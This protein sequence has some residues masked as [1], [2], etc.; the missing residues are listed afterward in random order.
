[1]SM[2]EIAQLFVAIIGVF[3]S[4]IGVVH[5]IRRDKRENRTNKQENS[6]PGSG[7]LGDQSHLVRYREPDRFQMASFTV[8]SITLIQNFV[9]SDIDLASK[10]TYF[11]G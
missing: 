7:K 1:M 9:K 8:F 11:V 5:S 2:V 10:L 4:I 3:V 6:R